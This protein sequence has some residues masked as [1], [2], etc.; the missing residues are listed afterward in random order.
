MPSNS[1]FV[2]EFRW[3][4]IYSDWNEEVRLRAL[5]AHRKLHTS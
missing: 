4:S 5:T 2:E 3:H 1:V